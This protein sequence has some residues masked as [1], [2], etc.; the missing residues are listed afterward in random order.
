MRPETAGPGRG[1]IFVTE[2]PLK[3]QQLKNIRTVFSHG[4]LVGDLAWLEENRYPVDLLMILRQGFRIGWYLCVTE[5]N[6]LLSSN[7]N[8]EAEA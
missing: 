8:N 1:S 4:A 5:M 6:H 2:K 7:E 3:Q